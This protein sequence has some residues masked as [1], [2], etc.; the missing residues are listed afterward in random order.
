MS[1]D[2][3]EAWMLILIK[4][5]CTLT[6]YSFLIKYNLDLYVADTNTIKLLLTFF[7][8][9]FSFASETGPFVNYG[10]TSKPDCNKDKKMST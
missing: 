7:L 2:P 8:M 1:C 6:V 4:L 9:A 10:L 3:F 5:V